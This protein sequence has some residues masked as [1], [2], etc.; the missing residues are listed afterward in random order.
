MDHFLF[1]NVKSV[2]IGPFYRSPMKD[3]GYDV[4][5]FQDVDPLFGTMHDFEELLAE[6]HRLGRPS[7]VSPV[8]GGGWE[9]TLGG[10]CVDFTP[11]P[12]CVC[13]H[14]FEADRGFYSQSHQ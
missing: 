5:D 1:L 8:G 7:A 11:L 12:L 6:M 13:V 4:E 14:R 9:W 3:F 2:W 10:S